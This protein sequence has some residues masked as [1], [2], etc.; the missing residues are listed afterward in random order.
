MENVRKHRDI[1][2]VTTDKRRNQLVSESNYRTIKWFSEDL[3][4]IE[5]KKTKLKLNKPVYLCFSILDISKTLMY[6]FWYDY[7]KPKY[8]NN[9][10]LC[11]MDAG[12]FIIHIK[13]EIFVNILLMILK[14]GLTHQISLK[15]D[16]Y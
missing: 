16:H 11:Y 1:K 7:I 8:Q 6:E 13:T 9:A 4:A 12:S 14:N 10:K 5:M 15:I 2:L 3:L